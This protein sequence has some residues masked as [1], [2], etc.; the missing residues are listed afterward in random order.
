MENHVNLGKAD[1]DTGREKFVPY[2]KQSIHSVPFDFATR[3]KFQP[4]ALNCTFKD[5]LL[6]L[7]SRWTARKQNIR[8]VRF[9]HT[10]AAKPC[11]LVK[12]LVFNLRDHSVGKR[13]EITRKGGKLFLSH[14]TKNDILWGRYTPTRFCIEL[15]S[16][17][18]DRAALLGPKQIRN[19]NFMKYSIGG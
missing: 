12:R 16:V 10:A 9:F 3:E 6:Q 1:F 11:I 17:A 18:C 4:S 5:L 19:E 8:V 13:G 15:H 7:L 2:A 14:Q